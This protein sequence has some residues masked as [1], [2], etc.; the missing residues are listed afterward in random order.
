MLVNVFNEQ[1]TTFENIPPIRREVVFHWDG[2]YFYRAVALWKD[3]ISDQKYEE[4]PRSSDSLFEKNPK[5]SEQQL[6][7][8]N[9]SK[10]LV[11]KSKITG[12]PVETMEISSIVHRSL[13]DQFKLYHSSSQKKGFSFE[14]IINADSFAFIT[15]K[16]QCRWF[17]TLM[18]HNIYIVIYILIKHAISI[19]CCLKL[20]LLPSHEKR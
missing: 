13:R 18:Y 12:I 20:A 11:R 3:E 1:I 4:I 19:F 16:K 9:S 8:S 5:V 6:F 17:G 15:T 2:N 14:P 7:F 10:D